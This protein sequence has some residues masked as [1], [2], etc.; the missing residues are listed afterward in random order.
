MNNFNERIKSGKQILE[1]GV[2]ILT[3]NLIRKDLLKLLT[4]FERELAPYAQYLPFF[5]QNR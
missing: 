4:L 2:D 3:A 5:F 1:Q